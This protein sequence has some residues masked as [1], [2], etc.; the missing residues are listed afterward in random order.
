[1]ES[2]T[3]TFFDRVLGGISKIGSYVQTGIAKLIAFAIVV[4]VVSGTVLGT[5]KYCGKKPLPK[6][7]VSGG[8]PGPTPVDIGGGSAYMVR[9]LGCI[10]TACK[11][12]KEQKA[13]C[14]SLK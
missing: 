14:D 10:E 1:M 11:C 4:V 8:G 12:T 2:E 9:F 6:P 7:V 3:P 5:V 13:Q